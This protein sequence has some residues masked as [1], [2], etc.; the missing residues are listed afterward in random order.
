MI[1]SGLRAVLSGLLLLTFQS[2]SITAIAL[3][4]TAL[5]VGNGAYRDA[6]LRNPVND[7]TD[8]A[9]VLEKELGF[10]V[11]LRTDVTQQ[12][13]EA[14]AQE[15][16]QRLQ[17]RG[18]VGLFYYAG[19]GIQADGHNYLIPVSANIDSE[20]DVK[21]KSVDA[22]YV[23]G[24]MDEANASLNIVIL[25]ACRNN[26]YERSFRSASRG[27]V[28]LEVP[29]GELGS[30]L[31]YSTAPGQVAADGSGRNSPYTRHLLQALR[32]PDENIYRVFQTVR[33]AV[34]K[35]TN[36]QQVPWVSESLLGDFYFLRSQSDAIAEVPPQVA[37]PPSDPVTQAA[38]LTVRSNVYGDRVYI[39]GQ[40]MGSTRLDVELAPGRYTVRVEKEG[41]LPYEQ[42][43]ELD[44]E[45]NSKLHATLSKTAVI[46]KYPSAASASNVAVAPHTE[47]EPQ[48]GKTWTE[49]V[50][51]MEFVWIP[52]GCFEMG[53]PKTESGREDDERQHRVCVDAFWLGR[54]EVTNAQYRHFRSAHDSGEFQGQSLNGHKQ[55]AVKV[56]WHAATAFAAWLSQK[57]GERLRLPTEAEWEYAARGRTET[58]SYWGDSPD[59][60]CAYAN[61]NDKT[62]KTLF[63]WGGTHHN[64]KD[65]FGVSAPVGR[66]R[67]NPFG[68]YDMLGNVW[69]WTC[70]VYDAT[71]GGVENSCAG[72]DS[73]APRV[74]RSGSWTYKPPIVRSAARNR[75]KPDN[76]MIAVGF[77]LARI[78]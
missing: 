46:P 52:K 51:G 71:Y 69:E 40:E 61:V 38:T 29:A 1:L 65:S 20:T 32:L 2:I 59:A 12:Q 37:P 50:T 34:H 60:A 56:D 70:S 8:V 6:P 72:K 28:R 24:Q 9:Q 75:N 55:P 30:L 21:Y 18:G 42:V 76:R 10:E 58:A 26:P 4:R 57:S 68:L 43:V 73:D 67:P 11:I 66:F 17:R 7:A 47:I 41:Y 48:K 78:P 77:R 53:S 23:L 22:G 49:P 3:E 44:G 31:A 35:E 62:S 39:D 63:K 33:I 16:R 64:C 15:F 13:F 19:H 74:I 36:G 14:A 5:V 54:Q 25:D 27:L 45:H